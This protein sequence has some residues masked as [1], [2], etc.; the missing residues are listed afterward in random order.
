MMEVE[1][2]VRRGL[3]VSVL[4]QMVSQGIQFP[5][6][7]VLAR[8]LTPEDFGAIGQVGVF[9]GVAYF[10]ADMGLG[11]AIVQRKEL[12]D[13]EVSSVFWINLM[14][15]VLLAAG[16]AL[17]APAIGR[18]YNNPDLVPLTIAVGSTFI[19]S[20][21]KVTQYNLLRREMSFEKL[22]W[23]DTITQLGGTAVAIGLAWFGFGVWSLVGLRVAR[24]FMPNVPLFFM[25]SF[26]PRLT[27]QFHRVKDMLK[28]GG[29]LLGTTLATY[30]ARNLDKVLVGKVF[31]DHALGLYLRA[32]DF[33]LFPIEQITPSVARVMLP[34][35]AREQA[36]RHVVQK[37]ML[38]GLQKIIYF[39]APIMGCT[40][41]L[42]RPLTIT[43]FGPQWVDSAPILQW[44]AGLGFLQSLLAGNQWVHVALGR[45]DQL[46]W[47]QV[48]SV[49]TLLVGAAVGASAGLSGV[50]AGL[51]VAQ[52]LLF[53]PVY[54][55]ALRLVGLPFRTLASKLAPTV[56]CATLAVGPL[57]ALRDLVRGWPSGLQVLVLTAVCWSL[58]VFWGW[59]FKLPVQK[60]LL[61][62]SKTGLE[63]E[64]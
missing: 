58:Y 3:K 15:G 30:T 27:F 42:S 57:L 26:R 22:A 36:N 35:M 8:L 17:A 16:F 50:A 10:L 32:Y 52:A 24:A 41:V 49:A 55:V 59:V 19:F 61:S 54:T 4:G 7:L 23:V 18:F 37:L 5:T 33:M 6:S 13:E 44:F 28:F 1:N 2:R 34:A 14:V 60:A 56:L 51:L 31:G 63:T 25:S 45:V 9:T 47:L 38:D 11:T 48:G 53:V 40:A 62:R 29:Y 64:L 39:S 20:S 43:L 21:L 12:S 46:F